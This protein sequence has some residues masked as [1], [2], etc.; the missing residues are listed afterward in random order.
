MGRGKEKRQPSA[1]FDE[2]E[3]TRNHQKD[4]KLGNLKSLDNFWKGLFGDFLETLTKNDQ[5]RPTQMGAK[6]KPL[7]DSMALWRGAASV[8]SGRHH[9]RRRFHSNTMSA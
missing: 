3:N 9:H 8:V 6:M 2:L 5:K 1:R 7:R 4:A